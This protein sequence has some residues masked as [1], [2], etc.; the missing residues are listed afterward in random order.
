MASRSIDDVASRSLDSGFGIEESDGRSSN[1]TGIIGK[2]LR[3]SGSAIN[4]LTLFRCHRDGMTEEL[5]DLAP[6]FD[7]SRGMDEQDWND[8]DPTRSTLE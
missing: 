4:R 5:P 6:E 2:S 7:R 1:T 3:I 8:V